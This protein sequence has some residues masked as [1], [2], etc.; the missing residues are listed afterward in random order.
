VTDVTQARCHW[1][2]ELDIGAADRG[3]S[4][5]GCCN[6]TD[7]CAIGAGRGFASRPTRRPQADVPRRLKSRTLPWLR[8]FLAGLSPARSIG[9]SARSLQILVE[10]V[11]R[12]VLFLIFCLLFHLLSLVR[13][14]VLGERALQCLKAHF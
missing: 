14:I 10:R 4:M 2:M 8:R 7:K 6:A 3:R 5:G 11:S 13:L 9:A 1:K 12:S